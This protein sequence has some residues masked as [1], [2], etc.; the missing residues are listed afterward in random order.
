LI[1]HLLVII[2]HIQKKLRRVIGFFNSI[3][4]NYEKF[5]NGWSFNNYGKIGFGSGWNQ[6][7]GYNNSNYIPSPNR[8][9]NNYYNQ[10]TPRSNSQNNYGNNNHHVAPNNIFN[11]NSQP[12][13]DANI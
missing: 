5:M 2:T 11:E 7:A 6:T 1:F 13:F 8:N 10:N 9:Q 3:K 12:N 4:G